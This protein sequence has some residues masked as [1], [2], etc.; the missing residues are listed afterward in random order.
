M[1]QTY[2][3]PANPTTI[4]YLNIAAGG[5]VQVNSNA[6]L[7]NDNGVDTT[8][9]GVMLGTADVGS[10]HKTGNG[11]VTL[12][13]FTTTGG[14]LHIDNGT[15]VQ[16]NSVNDIWYLSIG[17]AV[18]STANLDIYDGTLNIE[19]GPTNGTATPYPAL[20][21][22]DFGG[23]GIVT[24]TGGTVNLTNASSLNIGNQGGNGT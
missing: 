5:T 24:Q 23:T 3:V 10:L 9:A 14:E 7:V 1:G 12:Q 22:G 18:G 21:V 13:G 2:I 8:W 6:L 19:G 17:S 20:Q 4:D 16:N 15:A 11:T